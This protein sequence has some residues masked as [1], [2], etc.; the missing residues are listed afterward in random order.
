MESKFSQLMR[1]VRDTRDEEIDCSACLDQIAQYVELELTTGK[2][3]RELPLVTYH[4]A[5]CQVCHEE[6]HLLR[7]LAL[8]ETRGEQPDNA[9]LARRLIQ[10]PEPRA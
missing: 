1:R 2:P 7:E 8:L 10:N 9:E 3:E 6:Y 4:L 5:Q